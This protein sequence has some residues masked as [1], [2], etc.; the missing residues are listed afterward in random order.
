ML[1]GGDHAAVARWRRKKS[2]ERT[3]DKRP[4]MFAKLELT[5]K[6]DL[7]LLD[8]INEERQP[9]EATKPDRVP[10]GRA[11]GYGPAIMLIVRQ[12]RN[13]LKPRR[14]DQWQGGYPAEEDFL[15]DMNAGRCFVMTYGGAVAG[16]FCIGEEPEAAYTP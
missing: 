5:D 2:L 7:K 4:D 14:V 10:Q 3:M 16:F 11:G 6:T 9:H 1:L 15:P 13:Y 12:A 8:E